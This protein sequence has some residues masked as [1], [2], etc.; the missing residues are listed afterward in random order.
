MIRAIADQ[1]YT[2]EAIHE[3]WDYLEEQDGADKDDQPSA[4]REPI[5]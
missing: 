3:L 5:H 1:K 2:G 4:E